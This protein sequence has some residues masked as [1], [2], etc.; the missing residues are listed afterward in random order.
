MNASDDRGKTANAT[1]WY[2]VIYAF[3][4]FD[5]PVNTGGSLDAVKAGDSLPLRFSL[6]GNQG[7]V[8]VTRTSSQAAS[9]TDWSALDTPTAA[10][11]KLS[12]S[13]ST[14]RYLDL[15]ITDPT[16]KGTCRTIEI[17]LAD[18]TRHDVHVRFTK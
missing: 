14:E 1:Q 2:S 12:Y 10:Q 5:S 8:A 16:W 11:T 4:G 7:L 6:H 18:G 13:S 15:V 17:E 9:C 3:A